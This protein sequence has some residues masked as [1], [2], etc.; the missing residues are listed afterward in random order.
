MRSCG[1]GG[2]AESSWCIRAILHF[3]G[4]RVVRACTTAHAGIRA[5]PPR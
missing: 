2:A 5:T 1:Y 3:F 4:E